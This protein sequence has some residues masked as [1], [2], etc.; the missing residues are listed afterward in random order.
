MK[1]KS[2]NQKKKKR[3]FEKFQ[4]SSMLMISVAIAVILLVAVTVTWFTLGMQ[5]KVEGIGGKVSEWDFIVSLTPDG[6]Q[7]GEND[8][9]SFEVDDFTNVTQGKMAPGTTGTITFYVR[10]TSDV[11]AGCQIYLDKSGLTMK[12]DED[13]DYSEILRNHLKFYADAAYTE[14]IDMT[15]PMDVE[16]AIGES[17]EIVIYW[18]WPYEGDEIMP[19]DITEPEAVAQFMKNYDD[20]DCLISRYRDNIAGNITLS[21]SAVSKEPE[22][23]SKSRVNE[24][25]TDETGANEAGTDETGTDETG[26]DETGANETGTESSES[27][28]VE[29]ENST[30]ES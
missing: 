6:P 5:V 17:K 27:E 19:E 3:I 8:R 4:K 26:T 22:A 25:G 12:V 28:L 10:T 18:K 1:M 13:N 11:V 21:L 14:E 24:T 15:V 23:R 7:I 30:Q 16:V 20:E 29:D 2:E 9:I